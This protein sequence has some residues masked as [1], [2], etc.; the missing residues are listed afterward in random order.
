MRSL[1]SRRVRLITLSLVA[2]AMART[3]P[4]QATIDEF[5]LAS[6]GHRPQAI[7]SGPDGNLWVTEVLKHEILRVTPAGKITEF[8]VPGK[9]VG[10][11]QG[12]AAGPDGNIW[13]TSRE[14]NSIRRVSPSGEFNGEFPLPSGATDNNTLTKGSWPRE[15]VA[16][17]DGALYF[18]EMSSNKIGRITPDG[19]IT[20]FPIPT[21]DAKPYCVVIGPDKQLW[22][23][24]SGVDKIGRMDLATGKVTEFSLPAPKAFPREITVGSDGNL[25][26]TENSADEIGRITPEGHITEFPLS[27]GCQ[28]VGITTGKDGN[29]YFAEFKAGKIGRITPQGKVTEFDLSTPKSQPFCLTSGPDG[30]IWVA[31]QANRVARLKLAAD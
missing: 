21:K 25:W 29:V 23:T 14:E 19:K 5:P 16:A 17:P 28:P 27:K 2:L 18:A 15:I 30:N 13:F 10:V 11:L 26:F 12:I 8:P 22:F 7:V 1:T 3:A 4:A 9:A 6:D 20:E 24:E 31:E